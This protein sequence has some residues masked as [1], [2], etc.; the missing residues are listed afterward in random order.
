MGT[1][2]T[3]YDK[4]M[5]I[6]YKRAIHNAEQAILNHRTVKETSVN[7]KS[8]MMQLF[9]ENGIA[10]PIRTQSWIRSSLTEIC[11]SGDD[12]WTYHY[13]LYGKPSQTF[14]RYLDRLT[15]AIENKYGYTHSGDA[16]I[17][18]KPNDESDWGELGD[19]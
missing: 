3:S 9:H 15:E 4:R 17:N 2:I 16:E 8:L 13:G 1:N 11:P 7:G 5:A 18:S 12:G 6:V 14:C 19:D 10:L